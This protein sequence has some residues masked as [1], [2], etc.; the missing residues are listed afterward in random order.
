MNFFA[1]SLQ[2]DVAGWLTRLGGA[3]FCILSVV[4]F[5]ACNAMD[6]SIANSKEPSDKEAIAL[7]RARLHTDLAL[8]Y[9]EVKNYPVALEE[10]AIA[11]RADPTY[12]AAH[13][14]GGLLYAALKEDTL[15]QKEF[16]QAI[17]LDPKNLEA[18]GHYAAFLCQRQRSLEGIA[19]F[20][21][22]ANNPMNPNP[23][24]SWVNAGLCARQAGDKKQAA[25]LFSTTL[26]LNRNHV[27]AL[28]QL[29]DMAYERGDFFEAKQLLNP[30][31]VMSQDN[32]EILWLMLRNEHK[33]NNQAS[34]V[35]LGHVLETK[36][37]NSEQARAWAERRF[38]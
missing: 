38:D 12:S 7:E 36:F 2:S 22:L 32:V 9:L 16:L 18:L 19:S 4:I 29:S 1:R 6:P 21:Q 37:H 25:H 5:S 26:K 17:K 27:Q 11:L 34:M 20:I 31:T 15:A 30:L 8:G 35:S 10:W 14:L 3:I 13:D 28:Y 23:E 33:L 24:G